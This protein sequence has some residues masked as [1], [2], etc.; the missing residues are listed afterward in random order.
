MSEVY[1]LTSEE[2]H[3]FRSAAAQLVRSEVPQA[4]QVLEGTLTS[5]SNKGIK[6]QTVSICSEAGQSVEMVMSSEAALPE[7]GS[8]I[9][10]HIDRISRS[11]KTVFATFRRGILPPAAN[12]GPGGAG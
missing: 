1:D 9:K 5:V 2:L 10:A 11:G 6:Q 7:I 12:D 3:T 4:G 8:P